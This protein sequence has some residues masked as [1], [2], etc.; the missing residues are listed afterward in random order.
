MTIEEGFTS[1][2]LHAYPNELKQRF[3]LW[4]GL[5]MNALIRRTSV[6]LGNTNIQRQYAQMACSIANEMQ[7]AAMDL[8]AEKKELE[9][10]I[11]NK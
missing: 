9:R 11:G 5:A 7:A 1:I 8:E 10:T 2:E 6:S 3:N 4:A